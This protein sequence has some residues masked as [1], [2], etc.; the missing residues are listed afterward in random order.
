MANSQKY[1]RRKPSG[2]RL[3]KSRTKKLR[4][5]ARFPTFTKM[6]KKDTKL[7]KGRGGKKRIVTRA[8]D[9]VNL[10]DPKTKK[11]SKVKIELVIENPANRHFVRRNIITKGTI[12]K[13]SKG[14][15]RIVSRPGQEGILNAVLVK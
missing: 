10:M 14:N 13:T 8:N 9:E 7:I 1:S 3:V 4:E 6:G 11:Y 5:L 12:V 15:A 2:G